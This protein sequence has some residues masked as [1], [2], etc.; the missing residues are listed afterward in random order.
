MKVCVCLQ[1]FDLRWIQCWNTDFKAA[2]TVF[3]D[4]PCFNPL[5]H[6]VGENDQEHPS[7]L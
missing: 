4:E 6:M 3:C 2:I 7:C 1:L 5:T